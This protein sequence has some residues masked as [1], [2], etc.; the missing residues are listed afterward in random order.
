MNTKGVTP[1]IATILLVA[2]VIVL[3]SIVFVWA[4]GFVKEGISKNGE[5]IE[6]ACDDVRFEAG[7]ALDAGTYYLE[8][9]NQG[10]VSI[11]GFDIYLTTETSKDILPH[12][13]EASLEPGQSI[14]SELSAEFANAY[15]GIEGARVRVVPVLV[16]E[17]SG[18]QQEQHTCDDATGFNV[19]VAA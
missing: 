17:S 1:V 11:Y 15:E 16:G 3:A 4:F 10:T 5:P 18:G 6:R 9:N 13:L 2:V 19:E 12:T 14:R 7:I 8:V